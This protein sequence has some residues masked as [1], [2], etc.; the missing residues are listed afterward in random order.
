[1]T[2][3]ASHPDIAHEMAARQRDISVSEFFLKNRHLLG[4]DSPAKAALTTVKEAVDN[5]LDACE[6]AGILPEIWVEVSSEA[7]DVLRMSVEDNGPGIVEEQLGRIFGKLLYGSKFHK[8]SQSRGQQGMG[9]AA[10]GMYAQLT[11]GK[12]LHVLS[13]VQGEPRRR[14]SSYRS[15]PPR[16]GPRFTA[17]RESPGIARTARASAQIEGTITRAAIPSACTSSKRPL[18]ILMSRSIFKARTATDG[19]RSQQHRTSAPSREYQT[20]SARRRARPAHSDAEQHRRVGRYCSSSR[21]SFSRVGRKTARRI[22]MRP[23]QNLTERS[24]PKRIAHLQSQALYRAIQ[25]CGSPLPA[26]GLRGAYR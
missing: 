3:E 26:V 11:T 21:T 20:A 25:R 10:A 22:I 14:N 19:T 1:M 24:Y 8:L 9:I 15:T 4:F 16:I 17:R 18:S 7:D 2:R 13:R 5:A 23:A 6:E 12:P